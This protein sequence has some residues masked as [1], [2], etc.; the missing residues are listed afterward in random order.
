MKKNWIYLLCIAFLSLVSCVGED[1]E[2][3]SE[4]DEPTIRLELKCA[5]PG[6]KAGVDG[7]EDGVFKAAHD[8][9]MGHV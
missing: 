7:T 6:T 5:E 4:P 3:D 1:M 2:P 9:V 8:V